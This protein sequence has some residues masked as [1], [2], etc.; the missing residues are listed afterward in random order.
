MLGVRSQLTLN[1]MVTRLPPPV[2]QPLPLRSQQTRDYLVTGHPS[3]TH[4][5]SHTHE[6]RPWDPAQVVRRILETTGDSGKKDPHPCQWFGTEWNQERKQG[7]EEPGSPYWDRGQGWNLG[8]GGGVNPG[9]NWLSCSRY[10][11]LDKP[12][13]MC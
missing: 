1:Q 2:V 12:G 11:D 5:H 9:T 7:I 3:M 6:K 13:R 4:S 8:L 10:M